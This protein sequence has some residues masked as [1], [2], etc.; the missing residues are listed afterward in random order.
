MS[1]AILRLVN[2]VVGLGFM[3]LAVPASGQEFYKGK[4]IVLIV[5]TA[6]G[7]GFD[8]YSRMLDPISD[9]P[10]VPVAIQQAKTKEGQDLLRL[11]AQAYGPASIAYSVPPGLPK[12]R[13]LTLQNGFMATMKDPEFLGEAKKANLVVN[14]LDGPT[15]TKTVAELYM[16]DTKV[17]A[18]FREIIEVTTAQR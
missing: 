11:G 15:I 1:V 18:R 16:S 17:R 2:F 14:P 9:L 3:F 10:N 6:P 5:G 12:E 13:L 7:G 8:T 4:T